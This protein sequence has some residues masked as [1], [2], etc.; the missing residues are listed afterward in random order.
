MTLHD[1][2]R[3]K[4]EEEEKGGEGRRKGRGAHLLI[5]VPKSL[6][7]PSSFLPWSPLHHPGL[8]PA[9]PGPFSAATSC[10]PP[11]NGSKLGAG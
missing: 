11:P 10:L 6:Q 1:K 3:K 8:Q 7:K 4:E 9:Q 2:E 5:C